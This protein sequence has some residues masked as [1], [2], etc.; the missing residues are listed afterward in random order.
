L[1]DDGRQPA[2]QFG[3]SGPGLSWT[4]IS[5]GG[6][7]TTTEILHPRTQGSPKHTLK[8]WS[9]DLVPCRYPDNLSPS[10]I[11]ILVLD[12]HDVSGFLVLIGGGCCE[13]DVWSNALKVRLLEA[14]VE[15]KRRLRD[16]LV[17]VPGRLV[18]FGV[19]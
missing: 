16:V 8:Q 15:A 12:T 4:P 19:C 1:G 5:R 9:D 13:A 17:R 3:N 18:T 14:K 2:L 10:D 7:E 11:E 6:G